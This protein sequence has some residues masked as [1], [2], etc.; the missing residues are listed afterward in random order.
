MNKKGIIFDLY[1]T[2]IE[3][4]KKSKPYLYLLSYCKKDA[5]EIIREVMTTDLVPLGYIQRLEKENILKE[6][7]D[8]TFFLKLLD[9]EVE[10]VKP[11]YSV[12]RALRELKQKYRLFVLS[13]LA[14]AYKFPYYTLNIEDY[15]EKAFFS[16]EYGNIK[17]DPLFF[18]EVINYSGLKKEELIMIGD[19]L[20]SDI[21]GAKDFGIDHTILAI[22]GNLYDAVKKLL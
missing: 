10:S 3:I 20:T 19:N 4:Q 11:I 7:F 22:G 6:G 14:T 13:N 16:C 9:D 1:G 17:P 5:K 21:K 12:Y 2:L 15:I 8:S 18:E